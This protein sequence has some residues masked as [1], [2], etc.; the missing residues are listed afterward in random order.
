MAAGLTAGAALVDYGVSRGDLVLMGA[1]TGVGVGVLQALVL[2][3]Y[4]IRGAFWWAAASPPAW[5]VGWLV[6]SYVIT[7]NVDERFTNFGLSGAIVFA[8]GMGLLL[9]FLIR[10]REPRV[11]VS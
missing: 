9:A 10:R 7:R 4:R 5:A 2:A 6:T 8:V 1:L 3:R 11:A